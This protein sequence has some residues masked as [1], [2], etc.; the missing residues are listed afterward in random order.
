MSELKV[1]GE[2]W[3]LGYFEYNQQTGEKVKLL[4][5]TVNCPDC[6]KTVIYM[7]HL[8][9]YINL[10]FCKKCG[11]DLSKP[12]TFWNKFNLWMQWMGDKRYMRK[13]P[14]IRL[15]SIEKEVK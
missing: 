4:P 1:H 2:I 6:Y 10:K 14:I 13:Y 15:Y 3:P 12:I 9:E 11:R 5:A 8:S 7:S